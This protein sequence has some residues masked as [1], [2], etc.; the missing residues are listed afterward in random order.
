MTTLLLVRHGQSLANL[1]KVFAGNYDAPLTELGIQQARR[2]GEFVAENYAVDAIYSSD[3]SRAWETARAASRLLGLPVEKAP[4][5]RE[6]RAGKWEG[7]PFEEIAVKYPRDWQIWKED[8][9]HSRCTGGESAMELAERVHAGL[10]EIAR[11]NPGKTVLVATHAVPIR[12]M[13]LRMSGRGPEYMKNIPWVTNASVTELRWEDGVFTPVKIS[14]DA[15]LADMRT[16]LPA[17]V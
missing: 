6:I 17:N 3:L 14:Q 12:T 7:R 4:A 11:A 15:H 9:G 5:L 10:T 16:N 1:E 2:T 8:V 13:Q